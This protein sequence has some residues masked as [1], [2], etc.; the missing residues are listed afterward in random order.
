MIAMALIVII[1]SLLIAAGKNSRMLE[2]FL[3]NNYEDYNS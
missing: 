3:A 1:F 2:K